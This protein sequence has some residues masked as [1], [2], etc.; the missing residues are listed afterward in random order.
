MEPQE[1]LEGQYLFLFNMFFVQDIRR[2]QPGTVYLVT[3]DPTGFTFNMFLCNTFTCYVQFL[4][5]ATEGSPGCR[6]LIAARAKLTQKIKE[7]NY[8]TTINI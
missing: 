5:S 7:C 1:A 6:V 4:S 8:I 3:W 2:G